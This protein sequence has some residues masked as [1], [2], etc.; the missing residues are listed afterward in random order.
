MRRDNFETLGFDSLERMTHLW[1]GCGIVKL[2]FNY[3]KNELSLQRNAIV[4]INHES[5]CLLGQ[6]FSTRKF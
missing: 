1:E 6:I 3:D 2:I 4:F 5:M